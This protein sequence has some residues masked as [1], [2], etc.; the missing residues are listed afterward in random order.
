[1]EVKA[2]VLFLFSHNFTYTGILRM[3]ETLRE[4]T[5]LTFIPLPSK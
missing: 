3:A 2:V 1:M 4:N 5:S